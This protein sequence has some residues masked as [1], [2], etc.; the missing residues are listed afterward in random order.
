M[1]ENRNGGTE[2]VRRKTKLG[3]FLI[4]GKEEEWSHG[5]KCERQKI[6]KEEMLDK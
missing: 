5:L 4:S 6:W 1:V 3:T 2:R